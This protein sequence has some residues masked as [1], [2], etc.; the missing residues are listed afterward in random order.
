MSAWLLEAWES[1]KF[2]AGHLID[3]EFVGTVLAVAL[4]IASGL[5]SLA[6]LLAFLR[7]LA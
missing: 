1:F 5:F 7:A 4:V 6:L 2:T 3:A